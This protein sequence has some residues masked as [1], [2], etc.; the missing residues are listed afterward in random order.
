M[1]KNYKLRTGFLEKIVRSWVYDTDSRVERINAHLRAPLWSVDSSGDDSWFS[2]TC[3]PPILSDFFPRLITCLIFS[4]RFFLYVLFHF[5][6]SFFLGV[7]SFFHTRRR[8][9][10]LFPIVIIVRGP[11]FFKRGVSSGFDE[12]VKTNGPFKGE[13]PKLLTTGLE[14]IAV[15]D[16][17]RVLFKSLGQLARCPL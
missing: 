2:D 17:Y 12:F 6:L 1:Y 9:S 4:P 14:I 3:V 7:V 15:L 11:V 8:G 10:V 16:W 13:F 5:Y